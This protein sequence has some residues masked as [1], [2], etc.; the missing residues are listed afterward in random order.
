METKNTELT[1]GEIGA[2]LFGIL[3]ISII[4]GMIFSIIIDNTDGT[5]SENVNKK[6]TNI[7]NMFF[8]P[9][10]DNK[11]ATPNKTVNQKVTNSVSPTNQIA[12][13][14]EPFTYTGNA[15]DELGNRAHYVMKIKRDFS[16]ASINGPYQPIELLSNG[17][18]QF[19]GGTIMG[20]SFNVND[21]SCILYNFDR[22]Y[23][24]TL[25]RTY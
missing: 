10:N 8:S 21:R 4:V 5:P 13:S 18:Y 15:Q 23:F 6:I 1:S 24:C 11:T 20:L 19:I 16:E 25:Y 9:K 7:V 22:T 3:I 2:R 14:N 17:R 12:T